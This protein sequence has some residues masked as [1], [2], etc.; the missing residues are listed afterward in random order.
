MEKR[1]NIICNYSSIYAGNFIPSILNM[2]DNSDFEF[3]AFSFPEDAK[4]RG[5]IKNIQSKGYDVFFYRKKY[6]K[7]DILAINKRNKISIVYAHFLSGL[8]VKFLYPF[9]HHVKLFI[10]IHSD[11][12]GN[13]RISFKRRIK[14][15]VENRFI[16]T[17]ATYIYVSK[18][19]FLESKQKHKYCVNNALCLDRIFSKKLD[20]KSF[21]NKYGINDQDTLFLLF[22]WSPYIKG[23]DLAVKSFLNLP[24]ELQNHSKLIIVHGK[25]DGREKCIQFLNN[26]IGNNSYLDNKSIIFVAPEEDVF[27]LYGLADVYVMASRSEG[28]SYSLLEALYFDLK[29]I[30]NDIDGCAWAKP[31]EKCLFFKTNNIDNLSE[32][33]KSCVGLKSKH[34]PN[35][36]IIEQYD[37][38]KWSNSIKGI[39]ENE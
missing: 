19:L 8:K 33:F 14:R 39:L 4:E 30:V 29:C 21:L 12:S 22:A 32:L 5:W 27:S 13:Q 18:P 10:H 9:N 1:I 38:N 7:K 2:C 3:I 31:Y 36:Q 24:E 6:L 23:L 16:R 28:F 26:Q 20:S 37:I 25:D 35:S 17:D 34:C 15:F 11:F